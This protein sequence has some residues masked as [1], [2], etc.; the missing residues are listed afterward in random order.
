MKKYSFI[1]LLFPSWLLAQPRFENDTLIASGGYKIYKGQTL[2]LANGSSEAGYFRFVKFHSNM[3]R[4]DTYIL[5]GSSVLVKDLRQFKLAS[6]GNHTIRITGTA[7]RKDNSK[8]EVDFILTF[9]KAIIGDYGLA[10][11]LSVAD[12][13][14]KNIP[15]TTTAAETKPQPATKK[16]AAQEEP[17][18][19]P[20]P[21]ELKK[22]L[23][24]DEIKKLFELYKAGALTKEEY[25]AQKK[26][27]LEQ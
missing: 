22:L 13:F 17:K 20:V 9:D 11:E 24:A 26:K 10:P 18:K 6:S 5:Q 7:T 19:Q 4:N 15:T 14:R 2:Y 21:E 27:L 1:L 23:V 16:P 25:E 12:E 3:A 8:M